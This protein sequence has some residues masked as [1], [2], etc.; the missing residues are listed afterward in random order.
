MK[1]YRFKQGQQDRVITYHEDGKICFHD[2]R[3]PA[4]K[5]GEYW[6]CEISIERDTY[7]I[8]KL[9]ERVDYDDYWKMDI[10]SFTFYKVGMENKIDGKKTEINITYM[11]DDGEGSIAL[12]QLSIGNDGPV[13][14]I[15]LHLLGRLPLCLHQIAWD[16]FDDYVDLYKQANQVEC[17]KKIVRKIFN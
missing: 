9:L 16:M 13:K 12:D 15:F 8:I 11:I 6:L 10:E 7:N 14:R 17:K 3:G 2:K 5:P 4:P 1:V